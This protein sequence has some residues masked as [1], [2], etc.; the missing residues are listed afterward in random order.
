MWTMLSLEVFE[1][2]ILQSDL[3]NLFSKTFVTF[4]IWIRCIWKKDATELMTRKLYIDAFFA[5]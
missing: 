4:M 2:K 3:C 5:Y 1:K